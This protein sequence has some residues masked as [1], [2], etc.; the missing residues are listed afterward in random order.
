LR[1]RGLHPAPA[2]ARR[3]WLLRLDTP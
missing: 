2:E 1:A 3:R